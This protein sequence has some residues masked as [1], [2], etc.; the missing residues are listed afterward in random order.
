MPHA[1]LPINQPAKAAWKVREWS[2]AVGCS[3]SRTHER[4]AQKRV[5]SVKFGAT[6]LITT[7]PEDFIASLRGAA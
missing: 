1:I 3:R 6:R 5:A 4:I 7:S 2:Q